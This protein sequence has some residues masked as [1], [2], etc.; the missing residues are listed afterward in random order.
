MSVADTIL[1]Q[2]GGTGRITAM[3]GA[4]SFVAMEG[5]VKFK[6]RG[7]TKANLVTV[8]LTPRDTYTVEFFKARGI[9][10]SP[11]AIVEDVYADQLR[12]VFE[13]FTGLY[14]SL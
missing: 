4:H 14:L 12:R 7:S 2:M 9:A 11:I 1:K 8:R 3:T 13:Q 6:F 5:G 10:A